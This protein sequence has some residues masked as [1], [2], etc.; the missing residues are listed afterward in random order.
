MSVNSEV[1]AQTQSTKYL[2]DE[3]ASVLSEIYDPNTALAC[4]CTPSTWAKSRAA[5]HY[6]KKS[7]DH[8][9]QYQG[10]ISEELSE[11][12][13]NL[14][15][16]TAHGDLLI[17]HIELMLRMFDALLEPKEIGL[18]ILPCTY[19]MSPA[20]HSQNGI[21]R[22]LSTLGGSGERWL[23]HGFVEYYPLEKG[24]FTPAVKEPKE[25]NVNTLC[26]GDI[27]LVKGKNW[28]DQEHNAVVCSSPLF[29]NDTAKLCVY[30]D[31]IS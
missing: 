16:D 20:F 10:E 1:C 12:V 17:E 11:Q 2:I 13:K 21:V 23:E 27:A 29:D 22:M 7:P 19:A 25:C 9:F 5:V 24:Q 3:S 15:V 8:P 26:D 14:F 31:Y 4:Y 6:V 18:R 30:I 28:L